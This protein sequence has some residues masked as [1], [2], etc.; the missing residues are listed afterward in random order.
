[1]AVDPTQLLSDAQCI[2]ACIPPGM[3]EAAQLS[4]LAA[5]GQATVASSSS[6]PVAAN[7][8]Q[9][10]AANPKR[11]MAIIENSSAAITAFIGPSTVTTSGSTQGT[12]LGATGSG[13][14]AK[15]IIYSTG[16]LYAASAGL[17]IK[18]LEFSIP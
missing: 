16:A 8:V 2:L 1:M 14:I 3:I 13:E 5:L 17:N 10:L 6:I 7:G 18:V 12:L 15:M 9:I 4:R 11:S